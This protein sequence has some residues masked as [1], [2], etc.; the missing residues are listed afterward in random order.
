MLAQQKR[1]KVFVWFITLLCFILY[2]IPTGFP[3]PEDGYVRS[4]AKVLTVDNE[5]VHQRGVVKTG[6]QGVTLEVEDGKFSG[7]TI[8]TTNTLLGKL[9]MDKIFQPGDKALVVIKDENGQAGA[10]NLLD[11]YRLDAEGWLFALFALVLF[12]YARWTGAKALLSFVFTVLLLW[13]GLWPLILKGWDPIFLSFLMVGGIVG[14]V[15]FL[16][17]GFS[18]KGAAAFLGTIS[19][20]ASACILAVV[21]GKLLK[22]HGA[23]VPYAETLLHV[24]FSQ[25]DLTRIFFAGIFLASSGAMMDVAMD[26]AVAVAELVKK[27][28]G[29]SRREVIASGM[30]VGRAV[31]G[32]MTT[33]LLLAY[34]GS[35]TA[36]MMVFIA[37]GTPAVNVLNLTYIAAEILHTLVGSFGVVLVAPFTALL[38]GWLLTGTEEQ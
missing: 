38:S 2:F 36:L 13:K 20:A 30:N 23:V 31:V 16:V 3:D 6:V 14:C 4:K 12:W 25:L 34:S 10:A 21:F 33:T 17:A 1:N 11:H 5:Q 9:E 24:G 7:E 22:V 15:I 37:Q 27:K 8:E 28:P 26:I 29:M 18:R 32:T 35:F 19:G